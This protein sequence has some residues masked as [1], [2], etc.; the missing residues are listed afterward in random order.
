M[1]NM[2]ILIV[3]LASLHLSSGALKCYN[4][5]QNAEGVI[6]VKQAS[7]DATKACAPQQCTCA[8]Y[9]RQCASGNSMCS[10]AEVQ[11]GTWKSYSA[12][13]GKKACTALKTTAGYKD[14]TCCTTALC[15]SASAAATTMSG[16]TTM[17]MP[18]TKIAVQQASTEEYSELTSESAPD[19]T[20][21]LIVAQTHVVA[22][23]ST[24]P[25]ATTMGNIN[26]KTTTPMAPATTGKAAMN[27]STTASIIF[28]LVV[29]L[30][31]R[32]NNESRGGDLLL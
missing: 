5:T 16:D 17:G 1:V 10:A 8:V 22:E 19:V 14:V 4:T 9:Q 31:A 23:T 30:L 11:A 18:T 6:Q 20:Q 15:N 7:V 3:V 27:S 13:T 29:Y 12:I 21:T 24:K 25:A 28:A 2:I 26:S 32:N